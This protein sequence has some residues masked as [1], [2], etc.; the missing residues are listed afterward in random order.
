LPI[1]STF[2]ECGVP[3]VALDD[4][5]LA[6]WHAEYRG[7]VPDHTTAVLRPGADGINADSMPRCARRVP[8]LGDMT[9]F[10]LPLMLSLMMFESK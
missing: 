2:A 8:S 7:A 1:R 10:W 4:I 9:A 5:A 6:A 3:A